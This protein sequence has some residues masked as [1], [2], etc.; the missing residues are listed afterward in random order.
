MKIYHVNDP[1]SYGA[2]LVDR[3]TPW[4]NPFLMEGNTQ[5]ERNRV[6]DAFEKYA[7]HR[8]RME[9]T[10]LDPLKGRSLRC[11][12][13]PKRCHAETLMRLANKKGLDQFWGMV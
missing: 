5:E 8:L 3:R 6:C 9:P 13:A 12:C 2:V 11:W 4:G 1:A 7:I 10:W